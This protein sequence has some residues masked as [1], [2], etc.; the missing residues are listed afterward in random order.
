MFLERCTTL[1]TLLVISNTITMKVGNI[2]TLNVRGINNDNDKLVLVQDAA[3]Y[4][5]DIIA[6]SETH[7]PQ[8]ECLY[9]IR[10][11]KGSYILYSCNKAENT[12]HGVGFLIRKELEPDFK[13]ITER[14]AIAVIQ[15][16]TRKIHIVAVYAPTLQ[17]SERDPDIRDEEEKD[18][19]RCSIRTYPTKI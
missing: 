10:G 7:I 12:Y 15:M 13:R 17:T 8:E 5:A 18:T 4:K 19:H 11:E 3:K 2:A 9:E 6:L 1:V 16:K 14:I